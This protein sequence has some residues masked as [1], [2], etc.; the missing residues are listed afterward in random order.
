MV[1]YRGGVFHTALELRRSCFSLISGN[2]SFRSGVIDS[3]AKKPWEKMIGRFDWL[4]MRSSRLPPILS[5]GDR[6]EIAS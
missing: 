4:E 6:I 2:S 5:A 3:E 1:E